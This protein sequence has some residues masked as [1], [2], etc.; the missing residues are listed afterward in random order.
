SIQ[1]QP[2]DT[3]SISYLGFKTLRIPIGNQTTF[4]IALQQDVTALG[5]V[6][7]N[8]GYYNTTRRKQTGSIA[9]VTADE[10]ERQP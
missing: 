2:G 1:A 5:E 7:I 9:R 3:L 8:A 4:T 10:I 6:T